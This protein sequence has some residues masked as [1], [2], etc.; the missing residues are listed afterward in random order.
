M[1]RTEQPYRVHPPAN[2]LRKLVQRLIGSEIHSAVGERGGRKGAAGDFVFSEDRE[3]FSLL[4]PRRLTSFVQEQHATIRKDR[5]CREVAAK[6]LRPVVFAGFG[7]NAGCNPVVRNEVQLIAN[8]QR[9]G[10][11]R[12]SSLDS[13]HN[14][15]ICHIADTAEFYGHK[16]RIVEVVIVKD[17]AMTNCRLRYHRPPGRSHFTDFGTR[18]EVVDCQ[19]VWARCQ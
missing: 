16:F 19:M 8:Q 7:I 14:V 10:S 6:S 4:Y 9:R 11:T 13:P 3:L 5:R 17:H 1:N 15:R 2:S 18:F 12:C